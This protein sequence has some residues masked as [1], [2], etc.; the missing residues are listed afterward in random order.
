VN[1]PFFTSSPFEPRLDPV[2][3]LDKIDLTDHEL[4]LRGDPHA[5]WKLLR[6]QSP[7][8]WHEKSAH[9]TRGNGFW[10]VTTFSEASE[11]HRRTDLFSRGETTFLDLLPEDIPHQ[12]SSMDPPEHTQYRKLLTRSF[13]AKSIQGMTDA[14]K[15]LITAVLDEAE[16]VQEF[17]F[18]E[19]VAVRVPFLATAA[20]FNMPP[21]EAEAL[22]RQ[23]Q[24]IEYG[25]TDTLGAFVSAVTGYFDDYTREWTSAEDH[26]GLISDVLNAKI[27]GEP[28]DRADALAYLWIVFTGALDTT[29]H[30]TTIG[31]LSLFHHPDQFERLRNDL[32]LVPSAV[33]EI[34]RWTSTSN[35]IKHLAIA[36]SELGGRQIKAGDYVA[37]YLASANR[38]ANVF[39]DPFR[40]D[41]A[42]TKDARESRLFTFGGGAHL[43]LG[44]YFA[45]LMLKLVF[46]QLIGRFPH[47]EQI[48][49]AERGGAFTLILTP[50]EV[51]PVRLG[52]A[53]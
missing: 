34:L 10:A 35:V 5:S 32:S 28:I 45:R 46:E 47:I 7:V 21:R 29:A 26:V 39:R 23:L 2:T 1:D 52:S 27:D 16:K 18:L 9:G 53:V 8:F 4:Y 37:T 36:D 3:D 33:E 15:P 24:S 40:F 11:V 51:L 30:A 42:R 38:D 49:P 25:G 44:H 31:L 22:A 12:L 43:C 14:V 19:Q 50:L 13:T 48:G 17:N 6:E 20:L 41:V